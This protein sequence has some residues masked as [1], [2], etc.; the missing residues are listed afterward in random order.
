MSFNGHIWCVTSRFLNDE[1]LNTLIHF[2]QVYKHVYSVIRKGHRPQILKIFLIRRCFFC[3]GLLVQNLKGLWSVDVAVT[4]LVAP[5]CCRSPLG[6]V[7]LSL[8]LDRLL[9][10]ICRFPSQ[11]QLNTHTPLFNVNTTALRRQPFNLPF[12]LEACNLLRNLVLSS[13]FHGKILVQFSI[14][15]PK[16]WWL[17]DVFPRENIWVKYV[18]VAHVCMSVYG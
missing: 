12:Q 17:T 5:V 8:R 2:L 3:G 9:F 18:W 4:T 14:T 1:T 10:R 6:S 15:S 7:L 11:S 16:N 13:P